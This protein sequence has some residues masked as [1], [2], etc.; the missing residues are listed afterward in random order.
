M[1]VFSKY[2]QRKVI[3][4]GIDTDKF[5]FVHCSEVELETKLPIFGMFI[6]PDSGYGESPVVILKDSLLSLPQRYLEEVKSF[7][8]DE[9]VVAA[10]KAHNTAVVVS[11]FESKKYKKTGY[12][13]DFVELS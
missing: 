8:S 5:P 3:D 7:M 1:S 2:Q 12:D 13:V 10:V 4:W 11:T 9:D 6:V